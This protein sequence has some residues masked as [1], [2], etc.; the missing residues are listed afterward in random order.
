RRCLFMLSAIIFLLGSCALNY[1]SFNANQD[2]RRIRLGL[3]QEEVVDIMGKLYKNAGARVND[4]GKLEE[5]Y[6]YTSPTQDEYHLVFE[7][8]ILVE[9]YKTRL[10]EH[11]DNIER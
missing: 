3:T 9:W 8:K 10:V 2:M 7:D 6:T 5:I 4:G 1:I 11:I